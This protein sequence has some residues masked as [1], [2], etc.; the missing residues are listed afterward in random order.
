MIQK[1]GR[2]SKC[3]C[4]C[5]IANS[6]YNLCFRCNTQ[7]LYK[8]KQKTKLEQGLQSYTD[9]YKEIW[10]ERKHICEITGVDLPF[11]VGSD[12]WRSCFAHIF[13][14]S[15]FKQ[16][17]FLKINIILIHPDIHFLLDFGTQDKLKDKIGQKG[18]DLIMMRKKVVLEYKKGDN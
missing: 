10:N 11:S 9:F 1:Q 3:G 6:K 7:R 14:K 4:Q 12:M 5:N 15:K 13:P 17:A 8:D 18:L 16:W 2:C